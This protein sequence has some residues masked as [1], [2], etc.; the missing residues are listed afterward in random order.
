MQV[1]A[2]GKLPETGPCCHMHASPLLERHQLLMVVNRT[3]LLEHSLPIPTH[4]SMEVLNPVC[5]WEECDEDVRCIYPRRRWY[6]PRRRAS[7]Q[8]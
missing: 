5:R 4:R 3:A 8:H 1:P 6:Y 7:L 2:Q